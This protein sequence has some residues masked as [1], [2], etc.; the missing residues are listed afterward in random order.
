MTTTAA[1]HRPSPADLARRSPARRR[2]ADRLSEMLAPAVLAPGE[3][4][5]PLYDIAVRTSGMTAQTRLTAL[6]LATYANARTGRMGQ[7]PGLHGLATATG[8]SAGQVVVA[9]RVLEGRGWVRRTGPMPY[10][11]ALLQPVIPTHSMGRARA[12]FHQRPTAQPA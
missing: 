3:R 5:R 8:L 2:A 12:G 7:Q 10:E 1:E 4:F 6:T 11:T 9:L